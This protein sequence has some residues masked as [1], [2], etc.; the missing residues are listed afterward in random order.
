[1]KQKLTVL[2]GEMDNSA[3]IVSDDTLLT[4]VDKTAGQKV[5]K[6]LVNLSNTKLTLPN[7]HL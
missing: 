5:N 6:E 4:T 3:I 7:R 1:M 2:K